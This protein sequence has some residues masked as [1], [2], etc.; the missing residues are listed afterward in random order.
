MFSGSI[1]VIFEVLFNKQSEIDH[2]K[3]ILHSD[4]PVSDKRGNGAALTA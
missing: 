1:Y 3:A 4:C 2:E